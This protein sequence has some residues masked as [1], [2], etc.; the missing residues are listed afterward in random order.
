MSHTV[1]LQ[2]DNL[3]NETKVVITQSLCCIDR[4]INENKEN[5]SLVNFLND[6]KNKINQE[7]QAISQ[8]NGKTV[9]QGTKS[10]LEARKAIDTISKNVA[11]ITSN[12][13]VIDFVIKQVETEKSEILEIVSREGVIANEAIS[14]LKSQNKEVNKQN[15]IAEI[16]QIRNEKLSLERLKEIKK[17][18]FEYIDEQLFKD[19]NLEFEI[20]KIIDSKTSLQELNDCFAFVA[21]KKN[22]ELKIDNL[23]DNLFNDLEKNEGF[24]LLKDVT[25]QL[26]T[27]GILRKTYKLRNAKGN[28]IEII[29]DGTLRI[30]YKLGN[31]IG[32]ACEKTTEKIKESIEKLRYKIVHENISR[33]I[34]NSKPLAMEKEFNF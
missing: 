12:K 3:T 15:I 19:D 28:T 25:K 32:H 23:A 10:E 26:D 18:I 11:N 21:S 1:T 8:F 13:N 9:A 17:K 7:Y 2:L 6:Q 31:Y 16:N 22:E 20:K 27:D 33:N 30:K 14:N 34:S 24:K 29:I 5:Q 4:L